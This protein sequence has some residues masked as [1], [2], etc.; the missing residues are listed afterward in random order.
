[1]VE[2]IRQ[3][4]GRE[5]ELWDMF[6]KNPEALASIRAP[7]LENKV[8]EFLFALA[9]VTDKKVDRDELFRD[10]ESDGKPAA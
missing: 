5:Q 2:H 6:R 10:D 8:T 3:Y 4:P 9:T 7:I 1:V